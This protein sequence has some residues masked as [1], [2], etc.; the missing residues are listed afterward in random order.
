MLLL[1]LMVNEFFM[2]KICKRQIKQSLEI[3]KVIKSKVDKLY[4]KWKGYDNS[5][6]SWIDRKDIF[7]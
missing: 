2:K 1:I 3:E 6:D 4:A 5:F 7:A